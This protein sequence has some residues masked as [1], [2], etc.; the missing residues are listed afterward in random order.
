MT[1]YKNKLEP[2][3]SEGIDRKLLKQIKQRFLSV[4]EGRLN[5][6][7]GG[8]SHRH[9]DILRILPL[10]Y[11]VNHTLMPGYVSP[12]TP[13]GVSG[14]EPDK[15]LL[16]I[17][18]AFSQTFKFRKD[19]RQSAQIHSLF[20]MGSTGT[21]AHSESSDVDMWLCV[22][23]DLSE[24]QR[25]S[26]ARKAE[27]IDAW[28]ND[29]G[30]EL[31]TFLMDAQAFRSGQA[32]S[33]IDSE[34]SGSAQHYLLLDEFYRTAILLAGRYPLWWLIPPAY[35]TAYQ[36]TTELLLSKRFVKENEVVDFGSALSIPK[37]ELVGA[38]LW[39]LY[40]GL[41][42]P[43]KSVL[44]ILLAEAYAQ[45]LDHIP[46]LSFQFKQSVY[47]DELALDKLDPYVL[48]YRRLERYLLERNEL[49]RLDLV[50]KSF[51]LKVGKK[52]SRPPAGRKASWQRKALEAIVR[53][54]AWPDAMFRYLDERYHWKVDQVL[55]ERQE[56]VA[57]LTNSYR[58]LSHF[59][60][61]NNIRSSITA[62]DLSILGRK[63]YAVF[64]KKA[65]KI[66]KVNP[67]IAPNLWEE[68]LA[69][70][71]SSSQ[72]LSDGFSSWMLYR[73]LAT[74]SDAPFH[75]VLRK[76]SELI[77]LLA[78]LFF[79]GILNAQ[80]RLSFVPGQSKVKLHDVQQIIAAFEAEIP[81]PLPAVPQSHYLDAS[82]IKVLMLFINVGIDPMEDLTEKG[83]H[84]ISDRTDSLSYSTQ[85]INLIKTIDQVALNSWHELSCHR[86]AMGET[87][88]QNLQSYLQLCFDQ[89]Q[90]LE[91]KLKVHCFSPQRAELI[92]GRVKQLF[93]QVKNA[94]FSG[95]GELSSRR[96]T[97]I[98]YVL[99]IG[100][101]YYVLSHVE[102][103]FRFL[104]AHSRAQLFDGL[105]QAQKSFSPIIIDAHALEGEMGQQIKAVLQHNQ[106][107]MIQV[108]YQCLVGSIQIA[109]IDEFGS[110]L[111]RQIPIEEERLFLVGLQRFLHTMVEKRNLSSAID[112]EQAEL[113]FNFY[114]LKKGDGEDYSCTKIT[115]LPDGQLIEVVVSMGGYDLDDGFDVS[116]SHQEFT[117][118]EYGQ[119][120]IEAMLHHLKHRP[121]KES[122]WPVK[123]VD[124]CYPVDAFRVGL[125]QSNGTL[126]S[127]S[128]YFAIQSM[129]QAHQNGVAST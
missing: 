102:G 4:N 117:Y 71:H 63:L 29:L 27:K 89:Q 84:R 37:N 5:N 96:F 62:E 46:S 98:R 39:Q 24:A 104:A 17:A 85:R 128:D 61:A 123:L 21:L 41:D 40:K 58:F 56:L 44:K 110:L 119:R 38:G 50:R 125:Y 28:A 64:Q 51:Y 55:Q 6:T 88:M 80:T 97:P 45:E 60:R 103:Q 35:E 92:A 10:L 99:E 22:A 91:C 30:L 124:I 90:V 2:D 31:H 100:K 19:K 57:E 115:N 66:D 49:K 12:D 70:H 73:D 14:F 69:I 113:S 95:A 72:P 111:V 13:R 26:L 25:E 8:L 15:E 32:V 129:I 109:V 78:W 82:T 93:E 74:P 86:F 1:A 16:S 105:A 106:R 118:A 68:N 7:L 59:A 43:Y 11:Q 3:F 87:L 122:N 101:D 54:W 33:T 83:V 48:I 52:L 67:G 108:F 120:Q 76:S 53:D 107:G 42:A 114:R 75:P 77:D 18:K 34:S 9:Q 23:P 36:D 79:N 126:D 127:L 47:E 65:G 116:L 94:F 121:A 112:R 20:I 81:Q